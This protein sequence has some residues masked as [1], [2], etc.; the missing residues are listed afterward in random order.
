[1]N[2]NVPMIKDQLGTTFL[3]YETMPMLARAYTVAL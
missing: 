2:A 1:M 3:D